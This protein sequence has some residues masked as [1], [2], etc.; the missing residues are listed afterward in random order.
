ME[1]HIIPE[2]SPFDPSKQIKT[3]LKCHKKTSKTNDTMTERIKIKKQRVNNHPLT[4]KNA[5]KYLLEGTLKRMVCRY[6][7]T[8]TSPLSELDQILQVAGKRA[9]YKVTIRD[10]LASFHPF[11]VDFLFN[12]SCA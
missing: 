1:D 6:C 3:Y 12:L 10:M 7:L 5:V 2:L 11:K 4:T 8:V 9:I